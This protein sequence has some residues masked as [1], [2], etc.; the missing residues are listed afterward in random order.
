M[1]E[2]TVIGEEEMANLPAVVAHE[3]IVARDE[4]SVEEAVAQKDKILELMKLVMT[5]GIHYGKIKGISKPTLLKPGAEA[6]NVALRLAPDYDSVETYDGDHLTV[7]AKCRLL[8][9]TSGLFVAAGE[10]LCSSRESK[11]AYR[12]GKRVCPDC[13]AEAI[14]KSNRKN[15]FFCIRD[16]GGCGHRFAF[17]TDQGA[18]LEA[19]DVGRVPNPDLPDQWNTV[20]KMADKRALVAAVLNGTAASDVFTQDA[21]DQP[22]AAAA[23]PED[24]E[25]QVR[26]QEGPPPVPIPKSW[27]EL[28]HLVK[29][30][31]DN[32]EEAWALFRAFIRSAT[33]HLFGEIDIEPLTKDQRDTLWQKAAGAGVYLVEN[34]QPEGPFT[35]HTEGTI[36]AA[37]RYIL[38]TDDP[39]PIPDYVAPEPPG[40]VDPE[41]EQLAREAFA[42]REEGA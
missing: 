17:N 8:H 32:V 1:S 24:V 34:A 30:S 10:G 23:V 33:F 11:Y 13:H 2:T 19:Q 31:A 12:Q 20:L 28:E 7:K 42:E 3:A 41:T 26:R 6:I 21:E 9:I 39:L 29:S 38:K 35:F 27:E 14:V 22:Q 36:R 40:E 4:I 15:A 18:A 25:P 37:W 16:E 5:E